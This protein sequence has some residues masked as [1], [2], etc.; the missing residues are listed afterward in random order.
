MQKRKYNAPGHILNGKSYEDSELKIHQ[1]YELDYII[2]PPQ[3]NKYM[4][5]SIDIYNIYLKYFSPEDIYVYSIDEVFID[6]TH[7][8][9]TYQMKP[10]KLATKIVQEVYKKQVLQQ[11]VVLEQIYIYQK[12]QWIL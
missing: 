10:S 12:L 5:Y 7:Y 2:A 8:L 9:K 6:L 3:M 11:L 1:E 4:K